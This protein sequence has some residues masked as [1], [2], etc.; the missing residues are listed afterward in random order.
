MAK[1]IQLPSGR[2][3]EHAT[4]IG[5]YSDTL[6]FKLSPNVAYST[7]TTQKLVYD[8][9]E[10]T[11]LLQAFPSVFENVEKSFVVSEKIWDKCWNRDWI[12]VGKKLS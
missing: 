12:F 3:L 11:Q 10:I 8:C 4:A 1:K 9:M 7:G 2:L 5:K 6:T